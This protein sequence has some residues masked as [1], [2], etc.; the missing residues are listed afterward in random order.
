MRQFYTMHEAILYNAWKKNINKRR[1]K[2]KLK[3][4][5]YTNL[6]PILSEIVPSPVESSFYRT[7]P[8]DV[9]WRFSF[10]CLMIGSRH[11]VFD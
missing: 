4:I 6:S 3:H 8:R 9:Y 10:V 11:L 5:K 7:S 1:Q 2:A